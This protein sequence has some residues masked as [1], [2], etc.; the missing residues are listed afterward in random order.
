MPSAILFPLEFFRFKVR[1]QLQDKYTGYPLGN[2]PITLVAE[3]VDGDTKLRQAIGA[4][5]SDHV[6]YVSFSL[7]RCETLNIYKIYKKEG[8]ITAITALLVDAPSIGINAFDLIQKIF[9]AD[10]VDFSVVLPG[11]IAIKVERR[12]DSAFVVKGSREKIE[13]DCNCNIQFRGLR[14]IEDDDE[15]DR[16]ISPGSFFVQDPVLVGEGACQIPTPAATPPKN[17][18]FFEVVLNGGNNPFWGHPEQ[19]IVLDG[20][21][22]PNADVKI[23]TKSATVMRY[24]QRWTPLGYSLGDI[25]YSLPLAPGES[26]NLAVIEWSR[27]DRITRRDSVD[28]VEA[29]NHKQRRD[30]DIEETVA[31]ALSEN[32]GGGSFMAGVSATASATVPLKGIPV[33]LGLGTALGG[34]VTHTWGNRNI[35][36]ETAQNI[37]DRLSQVSEIQRSLNS[38]TVIQ[39]S[40]AEKNNLSTRTVANHNRCHAMTIQYF[41][42][43]RN[44]RVDLFRLSNL[45]AILVPF[46]PF[47]L[48]ADEEVLKREHL[49]RPSLLNPDLAAGFDA[50]RIRRFGS[51]L[52]D[53]P[54]P[55]PEAE[56][57]TKYW[58]GTSER[59]IIPVKNSEISN[60]DNTGLFIG[61]DSK[62]SVQESPDSG[63]IAYGIGLD[64]GAGG[65]EQIPDAEKGKWREGNAQKFSLI[66]KIGQKNYPVGASG[67]FIVLEDGLLEFFVNDEIGHYN[68]NWAIP[69][70]GEPIISPPNYHPVRGLKFT[71]TVNRPSPATNSGVPVSPESPDT[72]KALNT[73]LADSLLAHLVDNSAYYNKI[74]WLGMDRT[75]LEMILGT[76]LEA[77]E[78]WSE[79]LEGIFAT[80]VAIWRNYLA[81]VHGGGNPPHELIELRPAITS[82]IIALPTRGV[83]AEAQL[84][85]C[86]A[87]EERDA[88]R[89]QEWTLRADDR[90][91]G[92]TGLIPG[93]KAQQPT[94]PGQVTLGTPGVAIQPFPDAPAPT[95]LA[96]ALEVLGKSD[97]FRNMSAQAEIGGLLNKLAE[98]SF[99]TLEEAKE[100]AK[101]AK[102]KVDS[103]LHEA[104]DSGATPMTPSGVSATD[105]ADRL[106]LL[107]EIKSFAKDAGLTP[108]E[109]KQFA[110]DQM[111]GTRPA[112][113]QA[114]P[115]TR[116]PQLIPQAKPDE[117]QITIRVYDAWEH[118]VE[119]NIQCWFSDDVLGPQNLMHTGIRKNINYSSA[120]VEGKLNPIKGLTTGVLD[121]FVQ[122]LSPIYENLSS[123]VVDLQC[124]GIPY[125]FPKGTRYAVFYARQEHED[126]K[127]TVSA[128]ET[129]ANKVGSELAG[130]VGLGAQIKVVEASLESSGQ[131]KWEDEYNKKQEKTTEFTLRVPL[132]LLKVTQAGH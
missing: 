111:Y 15:L 87:C 105:L 110:M 4:L 1:I 40:Q 70:G 28:S 106:S 78:G 20:N 19:E 64:Y 55:K 53:A 24:L 116:S 29:L 122:I 39:I 42:V 113:K 36:G 89:V 31:A 125:S 38:T 83:L 51:T 74:I 119:S 65:G 56:T 21:A 6:G 132:P 130:K 13:S 118:Y 115:Q 41:E 30:R 94:F 37:R 108:D 88:T 18:R 48:S 14:S 23:F 25:R 3:L 77:H 100:A 128:G 99:K 10:N 8:C 102:D 17:I 129:L 60:W 46:I 72:R 35:E 11:E 73:F 58:S 104:D 49:L 131:R 32:Q 33:N 109:Y 103:A 120:E 93:P 9:E 117:V 16:L 57:E 97:I 22:N 67:T 69:K 112:T 92:L 52:L 66:A 107:P 114:P 43:L 27:E 124:G 90:A 50:I 61:A 84:G 95:A 85:N 75:E 68:D 5:V 126:V 96:D 82:Q 91:P 98:G 54:P 62:V 12:F 47:D 123:D 63:W 101:K 34:G 71:V 127:V 59:R 2:V 79:A 81:F 80:P 7:K 44:Y 76:A 86:I 26:V 121:L 45:D